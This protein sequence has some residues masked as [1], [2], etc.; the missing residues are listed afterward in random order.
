MNVLYFS[1]R[2]IH[3]LNY[4]DS[5]EVTGLKY[6]YLFSPTWSHY[7]TNEDSFVHLFIHINSFMFFFILKYDLHCNSAKY[8]FY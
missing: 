5:D 6:L 8:A 4:K 2:V 1:I 7:K 3:L